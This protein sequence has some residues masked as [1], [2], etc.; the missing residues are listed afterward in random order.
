MLVHT[1]LNL[2][3]KRKD[4]FY[5]AISK[6]FLCSFIYKVYDNCSRAIKYRLVKIDIFY[7]G[8]NIQKL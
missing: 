8:R 6:Y 3:V 2:V 4:D 7:T 1:I 5:P